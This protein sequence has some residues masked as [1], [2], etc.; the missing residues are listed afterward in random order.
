MDCQQFDGIN[1]A[2]RDPGRCYRPGNGQGSLDPL[3]NS[4][5]R[6]RPWRP[7]GADTPRYIAPRRQVRAVH[8]DCRGHAVILEIPD[9]LVQRYI[10]IERAHEDAEG[11]Y[12]AAS[13][14]PATPIETVKALNSEM[15]R[16]QDLAWDAREALR[17]ALWYAALKDTY[18]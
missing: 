17:N 6:A 13:E 7:V 15:M 14:D 10:A 8:Q 3:G 11:A 5:Q 16:T 4:I 12:M 1:V 2:R 18:R 9:E